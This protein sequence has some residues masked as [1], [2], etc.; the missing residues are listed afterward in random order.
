MA[1]KVNI[2]SGQNTATVSGLYQ[3]DYGQVLEIESADLGNM[4]GGEVHFACSSMSEAVVVSCN[5]TE[6][7][8][9]V[10]IPD[11]CLEQSSNITAWIYEISGTQGRTRKVIT[12]YV[13]ARTRPSVGQ[14][15]PTE[16]SNRYTELITKVNE[17]V[18]KLE[19]GYVVA[20]KATE[21]DRA[22]T[23]TSAGNASTANYAVSAG[24]T[25]YA[26]EAGTAGYATKAGVATNAEYTDSHVPLRDCL[27]SAEGGYLIASKN[28]NEEYPNIP[29]GVIAFSVY[30]ANDEGYSSFVMEAEG[31]SNV[32]SPVF[33]FQANKDDNPIL[34]RLCLVPNGG[35]TFKIILQEYIGGTFVWKEVTDFDTAYVSYKHLGQKYETTPVV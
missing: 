4:I 24:S 33:S 9:S 32:Y 27:H 26:D 1:I 3:W 10:T 22:N 7:L 35:T 34:A 15:I 5:F 23:A 29:G 18:D 25:S 13:T 14:D 28:Y 30:Y 2:P 6:G 21:A 31:H 16:I 20:Q 17:A 11:E 19:N 8:G 12:I